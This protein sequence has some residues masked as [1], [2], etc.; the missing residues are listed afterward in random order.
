MKT[1]HISGSLP[2]FLRSKTMSIDRRTTS[3]TESI[4]LVAHT[5]TLETFKN[6]Q[7]GWNFDQFLFS[8]RK[9][10]RCSTGERRGHDVREGTWLCVVRWVRDTGSR[11][12]EAVS[13]WATGVDPAQR[14][15]ESGGGRWPTAWA[16]RGRSYGTVPSLVPAWLASP[17]RTH[18]ALAGDPLRPAALAYSGIGC[19]LPGKW[20]HQSDLPA[21][22]LG[23]SSS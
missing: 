3:L 19:S 17:S 23:P 7:N 22:R 10:D 16:V 9:R 18:V 2:R 1:R 13:H 15:L 11:F 20:Q 5:H 6:L 14:I 21:E 8:C 12:P 4:L